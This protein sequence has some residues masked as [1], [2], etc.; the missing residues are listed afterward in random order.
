MGIR[1]LHYLNF[2]SKTNY[3][4]YSI[5]MDSLYC[6]YDTYAAFAHTCV[7]EYHPHG[8]RALTAAVHLNGFYLL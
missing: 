7:H 8:L 4:K 2:T 6:N 5:F 3:I 1:L